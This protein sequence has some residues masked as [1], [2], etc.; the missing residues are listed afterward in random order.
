MDH[1]IPLTTDQYWTIIC[2]KKAI[3]LTVHCADGMSDWGTSSKLILPEF[4]TSN[5]NGCT[6][7]HFGCI[8]PSMYNGTCKLNPSTSTPIHYLRQ[9][10]N[11]SEPHQAECG[12]RFWLISSALLSEV[13]HLKFGLA[14][15]SI[16]QRA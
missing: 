7:I 8:F 13:C 3:P 14:L 4:P 2:L 5:L 10:A 12:V 6:L 16:L 15:F 9:D 11:V 1:Q